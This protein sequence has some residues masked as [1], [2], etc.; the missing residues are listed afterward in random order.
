MLFS[1]SVYVLAF[2][3]S[4]LSIGE[5]ALGKPRSTST[6]HTPT[7]VQNFNLTRASG[8]WYEYSR[9]DNG[10]TKECDC[11]TTEMTL[12]DA[13]SLKTT[14]CCQVTSENNETQTC[15]IGIESLRIANPDKH[16]G[17]FSFA[18]NGGKFFVSFC[19]SYKSVK[20]F[21]PN[22]QTTIVESQLWAVD[23]DYEN[24]MTHVYMLATT[25][26]MNYFGS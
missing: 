4:I 17:L 3:I 25:K 12:V 19:F 11:P 1:C 7:I 22:Y 14:T 21:M 6:C 20:V 18:V 9:F 10:Y 16:E 26:S 2:A 23:T 8:L 5:A 24:F 15:N 13:T